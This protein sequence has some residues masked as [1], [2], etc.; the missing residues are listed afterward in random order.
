[1]FLKHTSLFKLPQSALQRCYQFIIAFIFFSVP[2]YGENI[3]FELPAH[4]N[5]IKVRSAE[6]RTTK[7]TL[8]F[9]LLP[10][11]APIHVA[12]FKYLADKGF[13]RNALFRDFDYIIQANPLHKLR[14]SLPPEFSKTSHIRGTLG[15]ARWEDELNPERRSS[16]TQFHI[17]KNEGKHMDTRYTAFGVL[18]KGW[19]VLDKLK[20]GDTILEVIVYV[21]LEG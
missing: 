11:T 20:T 7:G 9:E 6:I 18:V 16:S 4:N 13:F 1:M 5:I 3:P 15:M 14:Y 21:R 19:A 12:N 8:Y 2:L 10:E 17:L